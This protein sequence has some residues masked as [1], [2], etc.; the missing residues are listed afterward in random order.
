MS[1]LS[2]A[3][4]VE[5]PWLVR[6]SVFGSVDVVRDRVGSEVGITGEILIL[7][8]DEVGECADKNI[9]GR[10][11]DWRTKGVQPVIISAMNADGSPLTEL[12]QTVL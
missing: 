3:E 8:D 7:G 9:L 12:A 10:V 2:L 5:M 11:L 1:G 4:S 6:R